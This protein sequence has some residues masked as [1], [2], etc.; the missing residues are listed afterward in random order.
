MIILDCIIAITLIISILYS[1]ELNKKISTLRDNK[2]DFLELVKILD[3][4]IIKAE[5]SIDELKI[6]SNQVNLDLC[7]KIDKAKYISDDLSYIADRATILSEKLDSNIT[8]ARRFEKLDFVHFHKD[9]LEKYKRSVSNQYPNYDKQAINDFDPAKL[10]NNIAN[11]LV[12]KPIQ[13]FAIESLLERISAVKTT[14][15]DRLV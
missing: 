13:K 7:N 12:N 1:W 14:K 10:N 4:T 6:L 8:E 5:R 3:S 2:K 15:K 11:Q 9:Q